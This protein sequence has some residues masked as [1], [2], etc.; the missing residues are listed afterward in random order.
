MYYIRN[1]HTG[2]FICEEN[3]NLK[4]FESRNKARDYIKERNL[5]TDIYQIGFFS[6]R[7]HKFMPL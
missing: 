3:L 2:A 6:V 1:K 5:N 4:P 7:S